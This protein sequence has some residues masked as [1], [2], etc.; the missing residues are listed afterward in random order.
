MIWVVALAI[1]AASSLVP[2]VAQRQP[3]LDTTALPA[4]KLAALLDSDSGARVAAPLVS[5]EGYVRTLSQ[6]YNRD[7]NQ[8]TG[9]LRSSRATLPAQYD[10]RDQ[11]LVT[12]VK[13]QN[14]WGNCWTFSA[15]S[16]LEGNVLLQYQNAG[17]TLPAADYSERHLSWFAFTPENGEGSYAV[18]V[19]G[20]YFRNSIGYFALAFIG[21]MPWVQWIKNKAPISD[22]AK[23]IMGQVCIVAVFVIA[24]CV[25]VDSNYNPFIYFNF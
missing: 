15:L 4:E 23:N 9:E 18:G 22:R 6:T 2:A 25:T 20:L 24:C 19:T 5:P 21:C 8:P 13:F 10:L 7:L 16:A 14:P 11:G 12:G 17:R 1:C 3:A